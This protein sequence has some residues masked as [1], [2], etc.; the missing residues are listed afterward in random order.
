MKVG[1]DSMLLGAFAEVKDND[2]VLDIG[3]G[4]GVLSLML[5]QKAKN[6]TITA[7]EL[8]SNAIR[9]LRLNFENAPFDSTFL[10][11][12]NDF[13]EVV[14]DKKFDTI[15]SNPPFYKNSF[16]KGR[17]NNRSTARN[18]ENLSFDLLI[19]KSAELLSDNGKFWLIFPSHETAY[20]KELVYKN[21]LNIREEILI[22]GKPNSLVRTILCLSKQEVVLCK[23]TSLII[24]DEVGDY[25]PSYIELTK[26]FHS[27]ELK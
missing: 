12:E 13:N 6:L 23:Q 1:T 8:D 24:R 5:A 11:I 7:V 14:F 4:T 18:E 22:F 27:K 9:D 17:T 25:T 26:E 3:A 20:I 15:I 2:S 21:N 10:W 16:S 19:S